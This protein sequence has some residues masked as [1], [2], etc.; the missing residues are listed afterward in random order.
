M[1][2]EGGSN[3]SLIEASEESFFFRDYW[4]SLR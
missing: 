4:L 1:L 3:R 2:F